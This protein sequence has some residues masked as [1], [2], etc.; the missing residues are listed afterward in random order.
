MEKI[1]IKSDVF[2]ICERVKKIYNGYFISFNIKNKKYEIHDKNQF[3]TYCLTVPY[4]NLDVRTL[5]L[6]LKSSNKNYQSIID[7]I[8]KNNKQIQYKNEKQLNDY[9]QYNLKEI[10]KYSNTTTKN[11]DTNVLINS[12]WS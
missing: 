2:N 8:D 5:D 3:N 4:T 9:C 10:Y 11:I 1:I 7:E 6:I 12:Q